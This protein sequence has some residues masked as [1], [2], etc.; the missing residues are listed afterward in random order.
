MV[1]ANNETIGTVERVAKACL[2]RHHAKETE[3]YQGEE[4][5]WE[6]GKDHKCVEKSGEELQ[7]LVSDKLQ[8]L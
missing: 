8:E 1:A 2:R 6:R 7:N 5:K 3:E 4:W